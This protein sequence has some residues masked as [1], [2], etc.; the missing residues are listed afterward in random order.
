MLEQAKS[1]YPNA[2]LFAT[3]LREVENANRHLWL[4][5]EADEAFVA[6]LMHGVSEPGKFAAWIAPP[7]RGING[8]PIDFDYVRL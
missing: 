7:A 4:P 5:T 8:Q 6:S 2:Q 1:D 3:T